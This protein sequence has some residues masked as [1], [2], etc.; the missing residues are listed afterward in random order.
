MS[1]EG[2]VPLRHFTNSNTS[3]QLFHDYMIVLGSSPREMNQLEDVS[4]AF[5]SSMIRNWILDSTSFST[6]VIWHLLAFMMEEDPRHPS[7]PQAG[8]SQ[9]SPWHNYCRQENIFQPQIVGLHLY[10]VHAFSVQGQQVSNL[11]F[12][13]D[14]VLPK[15]THKILPLPKYFI[16]LNLV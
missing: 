7:E 11:A 14:R 9:W 12:K 6:I 16:H 4:H 10:F 1:V 13:C 5:T 8:W 3:C 15:K 2:R